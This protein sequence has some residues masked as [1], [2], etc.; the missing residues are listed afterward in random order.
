MIT[1]SPTFKEHEFRKAQAS[2]PHRD[3][4]QVARRD[5]WVEI[6]DDKKVFEAPDDHR[7]VFTAEQFDEFLTS[8]RS[9]DTDN[10]CLDMTRHTDGTYTF[11]H[12][13]PSAAHTR[14]CELKFSEAEV[15]AF[16]DG[17]RRRDFDRPAYADGRG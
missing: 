7:L 5:G 12:A 1:V 11:R 3:C 4:V 6:R 15:A 9:G 10:R 16:L 14:A 2:D 8:V 17:V 13:V